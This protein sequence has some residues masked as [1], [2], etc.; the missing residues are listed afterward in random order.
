MLRDYALILDRPEAAAWRDD[1]AAIR[2]AL[3]RQPQLYWTYRASRARRDAVWTHVQEQLRSLG[4]P[5]AEDEM[6]RERISAEAG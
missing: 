1:I 2:A 4:F 6:D 3:A 5:A